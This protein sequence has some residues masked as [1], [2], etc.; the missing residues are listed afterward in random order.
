MA[1]A[2]Y[3]IRQFAGKAIG[4]GNEDRSDHQGGART[5]FVKNQR[6][7]NDIEENRDCYKVPNSDDSG[8]QRMLPMRTVESKHP[9]KWRQVRLD[10]FL[11]MQNANGDGYDRL[12]YK[13]KFAWSG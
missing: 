8:S 12:H 10:I 6:L 5:Y 3:A 9:K 2:A 1:C 13:A 4:N 7:S 11:S